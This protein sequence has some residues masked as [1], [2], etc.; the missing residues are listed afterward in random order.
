MPLASPLIAARPRKVPWL[1]APPA[2]AELEHVVVL[3]GGDPVRADEVADLAPPSLVIAADSGIAVANVLDLR[4]DLLVGD[5]DSVAGDD[6]TAAEA[7]GVA[8]ERHPAEKD[9][10]DLAIALDVAVAHRPRL[11]TVVGG[12]GGRLDHLLG[13]ALLLASPDYAAAKLV[14]RFGPATLTVIREQAS[15]TGRVGEVVSLLPVH[16][17]ALGVT[18]RGLRFPLLD[19]ELSAGSSRGVSNVFEEHL[20]E[21][22]LRSGTLLSV[23]PGS[24]RSAPSGAEGPHAPRAWA[25]DQ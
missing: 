21:V 5:L 25:V 22:R 12:H 16:G 11:V 20:V 7:A 1:N 3:A 24:P 18:T 23:Q 17:P 8:V 4:V 2:H 14:G 19:E 9:R 13:N 10:T 6:L 15:L